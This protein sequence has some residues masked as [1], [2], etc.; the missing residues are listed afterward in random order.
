VSV[1]PAT[2]EELARSGVSLSVPAA[3]FLPATLETLVTIVVST[4]MTIT[5]RG[6]GSLLPATLNRLAQ[7]GRQHLVLEL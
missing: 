2:A 1:L 3:S 5:I 7:I 6:A 4:G